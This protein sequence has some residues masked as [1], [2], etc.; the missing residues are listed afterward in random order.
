[1]SLPLRFTILNPFHRLLRLFGR[2]W[3]DLRFYKK[4]RRRMS[5]D[6][7]RTFHEK[8]FWLMRHTD[9]SRWAQLADKFAVRDFVA[10][11]VCEHI[12]PKLYGVWDDVDQ[13]DFSSISIPCVFKTNNGC[14][15]NIFIRTAADLEPEK[16]KRELRKYLTIHYGDLTGE[17]HYEFIPPKIICEELMIDEATRHSSLIDYNFH[18]FNGEPLLCQIFTDRQPN[19]HV[20]KA[21]FFDMNLNPRPE[22]F[23]FSVTEA[24]PLTEMERP[25]SWDHMQAVARALSSGFPYVRVDLY[26]I[27]GHTRFGEMTFTPGFD[28]FY[29]ETME[30]EMGQMLKLPEKL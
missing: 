1:M 8:V 28:N 13:I 7:P 20:F 19:S 9:T 10:R 17:S 24:E 18:C 14:T 15:T 21:M 16:I 6:N 11:R 5:D 26:G 4:F 25:L 2:Q 22:Y 12:L 30:D 27:N 23:D 3:L 29:T